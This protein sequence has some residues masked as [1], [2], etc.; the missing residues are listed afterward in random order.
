MALD[1]VR[2]NIKEKIKYL[3]KITEIPE[4][5]YSIC[6]IVEKNSIF[7]SWMK[8]FLRLNVENRVLER[9]RKNIHIPFKPCEVMPLK[10]IVDFRIEDNND[11]L[12]PNKVFI[13]FSYNKEEHVYRASYKDGKI[14]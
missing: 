10:N 7:F 11:H 3:Y 2:D 12:E 8:R 5:P 4:K 14:W 1:I 13:K 6:G 9:Y